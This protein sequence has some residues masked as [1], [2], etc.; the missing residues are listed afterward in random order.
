MQEEK[1]NGIIVEK[2]SIL[3]TDA[4]ISGLV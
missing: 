4:V 3:S 1:K 2:N